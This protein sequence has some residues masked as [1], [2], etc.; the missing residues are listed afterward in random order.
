MMVPLLVGGFGK[1]E[2]RD[3][4]AG[5]AKVSVFRIRLCLERTGNLSQPNLRQPFG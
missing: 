2:D 4:S 1:G 3:F 5:R